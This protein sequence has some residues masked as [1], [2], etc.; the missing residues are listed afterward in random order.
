LAEEPGGESGHG[1]INAAGLP[2]AERMSLKAGIT[3][4]PDREQL[5]R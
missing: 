4:D 1:Q 3:G 2:E 5:P